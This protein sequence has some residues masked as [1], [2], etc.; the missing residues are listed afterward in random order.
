MT[1]SGVCVGGGGEC[2]KGAKAREWVCVWRTHYFVEQLSGFVLIPILR[3]PGTTEH[4]TA[5]QT[6]FLCLGC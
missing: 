5:V 4:K 2:E 6:N 1:I 3:L